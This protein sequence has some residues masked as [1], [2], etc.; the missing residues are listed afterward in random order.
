MKKLLPFFYLLVS[1][2]VAAD[3]PNV[4]IVMTDD[5]GY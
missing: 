1:S 4:I 5:M 3:K 2:A